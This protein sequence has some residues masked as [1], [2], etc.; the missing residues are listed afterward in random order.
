VFVSLHHITQT[1]DGSRL[2]MSPALMRIRVFVVRKCL[3][4]FMGTQKSCARVQVIEVT[5]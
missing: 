5:S 2:T 1:K 3:S 4:V